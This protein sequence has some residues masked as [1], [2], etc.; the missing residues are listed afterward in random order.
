MAASAGEPRGIAHAERVIR[1]MA[2]TTTSPVAYKPNTGMTL[3]G[4]QI[5]TRSEVIYWMRR[6]SRPGR[7]EG[8]RAPSQGTA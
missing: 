2:K 7:S 5:E 3:V 6:N 8:S 4:L 1:Q